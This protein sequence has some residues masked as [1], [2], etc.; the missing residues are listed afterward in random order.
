M[1]E[2]RQSRESLD[3]NDEQ[4]QQRIQKEYAL[5]PE[6]VQDPIIRRALE[7]FDE[8][9]R[10]FIQAKSMNYDQIQDP[11]TRRALMRLESNLKRTIPSTI[12]GSNEAW[13]T[14]NYTLGSLQPT[15]DRLS[16]YSSSSQSPTSNNRAKY[17]SVH[18][19]SCMPISNEPSDVNTT[20]FTNEHNIPI[21]HVPTQAVYDISNSHHQQQQPTSLRQRSRSEDVLASRDLTIGQTTNVDGVDMS[22]ELQRNCSSN[23]IT[24]NELGFR[25]PATLIKS[26]EP[27][28]V[29]TTE[30][31]VSYT[32]PTQTYSAYSCEYTRPHRNSLLTSTETSAIP[33]H[34]TNRSSSPKYS[35]QEQNEIQRP[36]PYRSSVGNQH[37]TQYSSAFEPA[38]SSTSTA[39]NY[40]SQQ[41]LPNSSY[42]SIYPSENLNST[43]YSED[44]MY[45]GRN[46]HTHKMSI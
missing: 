45:I 33:K 4:Q 1:R 36:I 15:N 28:F 3:T 5:K 39:N 43:S 13:Y 20:T 44:P 22:S 12:N 9:N 46:I 30:S 41:S 32:T 24:L 31:S 17:I 25:L 10:R 34:E 37:E 6:E 27:N 21:M 8:N 40:Y 18:Q 26:I 19:P 42:S 11:V 29:R 35:Q 2:R 16:R 14:E 7:R 38:R 23:E